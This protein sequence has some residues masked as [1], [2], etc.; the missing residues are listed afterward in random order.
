MS[1]G[2]TRTAQDRVTGIST[3]QGMLPETRDALNAM[4]RMRVFRMGQTVV[5]E[6]ETPDFVG[7][8]LSGLLRM[9]KTLADGRHHIVGLLVEGDIFGRVFGGATE[10][11]IEVATDAEFCAFPRGEFEEL[12]MRSPDLDRAVMLNTL[13]ELDRAR[14]WM[15]ILSNQ[16]ITGRIAG[17][18][19]L[20]VTRFS[21]IDHIVKA[22]DG[23]I[24]IRI[25]IG[26]QDLAHL[27]GTR[28]ES[29]SRALHALQDDSAIRIIEPNLIG[30][31][32]LSALAR[33]AGEDEVDGIRSVRE[34]LKVA[35]LDR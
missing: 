34:L 26:R 35:R 16:K 6:G 1:K 9:Q 7:C 29:I 33:E 22:R 10:F 5:Q 14:D 23:G 15:I 21:T 30:V 17:F 8:V 4:C 18:L 28:P 25:P 32:D 12:L 31:L 19:L 13:N 3:L 20:M 11:A 24:E 27:L 2:T